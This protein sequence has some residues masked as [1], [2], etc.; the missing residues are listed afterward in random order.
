MQNGNNT[1]NVNINAPQNKSTSLK[2][3]MK[4]VSQIHVS[5]CDS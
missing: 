1:T 5:S 4:Y 3:I 2:C